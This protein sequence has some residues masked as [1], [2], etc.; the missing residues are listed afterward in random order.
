MLVEDLW[1]IKKEYRNLNKQEIYNILI[2]TNKKKPAFN[3][4]WLMEILSIYP[5]EQLL[6]QYYMIKHLI[7]PKTKNMIYRNF[8][9][10][11]SCGAFACASTA[12]KGCS[13]V[14]YYQSSAFDCLY[15][16]CNDHCNQWVFLLILFLF[17]INSFEW[18]WTC[19]L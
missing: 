17:P 2:K 10:K 16:L 4:I 9:K 14:N 8:D 12:N 13:T 1:K 3:M 5:E 11:S 6:I 7:L 15:L 18:S 19:F